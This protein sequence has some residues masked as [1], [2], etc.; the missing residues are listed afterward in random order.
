M[1]ILSKHYETE[2]A[3]VDIESERVDRF[4]KNQSDVVTEYPHPS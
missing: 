1:S 2:I 3:V 4:G